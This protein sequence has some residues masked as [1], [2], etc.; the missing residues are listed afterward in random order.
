L[1]LIIPKKSSVTC[2]VQGGM[3]KLEE[4]KPASNVNNIEECRKPKVHVVNNKVGHVS[5]WN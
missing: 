2:G 1:K 4:N 5:I 3:G